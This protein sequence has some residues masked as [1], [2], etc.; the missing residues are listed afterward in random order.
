MTTLVDQ[1]DHIE[2]VL[3]EI[4]ELIKLDFTCQTIDQINHVVNL[5]GEFMNI[6]PVE[7]RNKVSVQFIKQVIGNLISLIF[8]LM[9]LLS[10]KVSDLKSLVNSAD[11]STLLF[12]ASLNI[13]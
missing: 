12:A 3:V 1:I 8:T 4:R 7:R 2:H 6:F 13:P 9:A 11:A 5:G 10:S